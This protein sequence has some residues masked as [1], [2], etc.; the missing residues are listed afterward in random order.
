MDIKVIVVAL[1]TNAG[2]TI[3]ACTPVPFNSQA[4]ALV[5]VCKPPLVHEYA[6]R[7]A[8]GIRPSS[9][10]TLRMSDLGPLPLDRAT[11]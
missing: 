8:A 6:A 11:R 9:E 10:P 5:Q 2:C 4:R 1:T 3:N 7:R